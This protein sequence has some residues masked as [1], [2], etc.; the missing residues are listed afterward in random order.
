MALIPVVK[1]VATFH[2]P[3][4]GKNWI[5]IGDAAGHVNLISGSGIIFALADGL[6]SANAI[7]EGYPKRFNKNWVETYGQSIFRDTYLRALIYRRP[8]LELYCLYMKIRG[9]ISFD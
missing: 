4:A 7:A 6:L 5:L 8:M 3:I 1:N 2:I 9:L